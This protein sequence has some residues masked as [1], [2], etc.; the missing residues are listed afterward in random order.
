[1]IVS[2][3]AKSK[4]NFSHV[5]LNHSSNSSWFNDYYHG[6]LLYQDVKFIIF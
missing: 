6:K 5:Q 1:M 4:C 3:D 2:C